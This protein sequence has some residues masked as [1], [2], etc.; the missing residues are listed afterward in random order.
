[1]P[2]KPPATSFHGPRHFR[3]FRCAALHVTSSSS[4]S[5]RHSKTARCCTG[6]P[7]VAGG[8]DSHGASV[9]ERQ[10]LRRLRSGA[11]ADG[12][13]RHAVDDA[14]RLQR[15]L[16]LTSNGDSPVA[17]WSGAVDRGAGRYEL[18][19]VVHGY[20]QGRRI[21]DERSRRARVLRLP[22]LAGLHRVHSL[23]CSRRPDDVRHDPFESPP[24]DV[25]P[26][27]QGEHV[28]EPGR[29]LGAAE[30]RVCDL[31][32]WCREHDH[33]CTRSS[34]D[35]GLHVLGRPGGWFLLHP[36]P[37]LCL[38]RQSV[39][40]CDLSRC[41]RRKSQLRPAHHRPARTAGVGAGPARMPPPTY[42]P[43]GQEG[44]TFMAD[45]ASVQTTESD[46]AAAAATSGS[47]KSGLHPRP[48]TRARHP[49]STCR[50]FRR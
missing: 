50:R 12:E 21:E 46:K 25:R 41:D 47:T 15:C 28:D 17:A 24:G 3:G 8:H 36:V 30:A 48:R 35:A 7:Q 40:Q 10:S 20:R 32:R 45:T 11:R 2:T 9:D 1:M 34:T 6:P 5:L 22:S 26:V 4:R 19:R 33:R 16:G 31:G 42:L 38:Q 23:A 14:V 43:D 44:K 29:W 39:R 18:P 49:I 13:W 27:E 37:R